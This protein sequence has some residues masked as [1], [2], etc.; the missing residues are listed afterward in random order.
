MRIHSQ[1]QKRKGRNYKYTY[2]SLSDMD[3]LYP[4][5]HK[6]HPLAVEIY[7]EDAFMGGSCLKL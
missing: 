7:F 5:I 2:N 4:Y 6:N 1:K 3:T